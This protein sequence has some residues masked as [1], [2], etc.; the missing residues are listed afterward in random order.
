MDWPTSGQSPSWLICE[1][2][3]RP[4]LKHSPNWHRLPNWRKMLDRSSAKAQSAYDYWSLENYCFAGLDCYCEFDCTEEWPSFCLSEQAL[5]VASTRPPHTEEYGS[6]PGDWLVAA[7]A[8]SDA[9][10]AAMLATAGSALV[11]HQST[12]DD[13]CS[14]ALNCR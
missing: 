7:E 6:L 1:Q 9:F 12:D 3:W 4:H 11:G 13:S 8:V 2:A 5:V 10:L 14:F